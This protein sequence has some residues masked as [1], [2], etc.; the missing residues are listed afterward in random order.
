MIDEEKAEKYHDELV[1][2]INMKEANEIPDRKLKI[3]KD[4]KR[5][6]EALSDK[7]ELIDNEKRLYREGLLQ[8]NCVYSYLNYIEKGECVVFSY[9]DNSNKRFTIEFYIS[10]GK[11]YI[12]QLS[13]KY[14]SKEGTEKISSELMMILKE[15]NRNV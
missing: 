10:D 8:E 11:Y 4:Y 15:L 5:L 1:K 2:K 13:G 3:H 6:I 14:N 12:N 7:Y 9:V